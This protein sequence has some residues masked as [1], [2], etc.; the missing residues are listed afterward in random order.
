M[1][2]KPF[3]EFRK[4]MISTYEQPVSYAEGEHPLVPIIENKTLHAILDILEEYH[5]QYYDE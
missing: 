3:D 5:K 2:N 4:E 1:S